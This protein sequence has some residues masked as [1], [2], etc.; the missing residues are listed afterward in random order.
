MGPVSDQAE[1]DSSQV[2]IHTLAM[3]RDKGISGGD[4]T[5]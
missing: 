5:I 4:C 2:A 3:L 1:T